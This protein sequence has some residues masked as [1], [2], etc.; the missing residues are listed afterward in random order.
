MHVTT[1]PKFIKSLN[2]QYIK[3]Y[4]TKNQMQKG[5]VEDKLRRHIDYMVLN[6][7]LE[8]Y[9][10]YVGSDREPGEHLMNFCHKCLGRMRWE[11]RYCR[12]CGG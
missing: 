3:D 12:W 6:F 11:E 10:Y 8:P 4:F 5:D 1:P 7:I 9:K 2:K